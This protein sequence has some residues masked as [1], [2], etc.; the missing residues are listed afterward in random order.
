MFQIYQV[1]SIFQES[2][3]F[4]LRDAMDYWAK[5]IYSWGIFSAEVCPHSSIAV[6]MSWISCPLNDLQTGQQVQNLWDGST[7]PEHCL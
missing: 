3:K 4:H 5:Y 7:P 6:R 1:E 2:T